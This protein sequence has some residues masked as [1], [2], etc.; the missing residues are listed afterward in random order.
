MP[1]SPEEREARLRELQDEYGISE[2][3]AEEFR[4]LLGPKSLREQNKELAAQAKK[5]PDL[6]KELASFKNAGKVREAFEK[7]GLDWD[8]LEDAPLVKESVENFAEFEDEEKVAAFIERYKL[9]TIAAPEGGSGDEGSGAAAISEQAR[10]ASRDGLSSK[11]TISA[12]D[13]AAW[14]PDKIA[15]FQSDHPELYQK[16]LEG[17]QVVAPV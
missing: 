15:K 17:E 7:A 16:A 1:L 12:K 10:R 2:E 14:P 9:P 5:V 11:T 6:E 4:D 3:H 13:I 8:A